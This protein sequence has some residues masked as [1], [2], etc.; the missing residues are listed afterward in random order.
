MV[1]PDPLSAVLVQGE[2][3]SMIG[4]SLSHYKILDKLGEGGMG[5]VYSAEDTR[6][7][8][9]V[10]LKV[11]SD[12]WASDPDHL[13]RFE[14]EARAVAA[15]DHPNI[16]TIFSVE[17][18]EGMRFFT[19][20]LVKGQTLDQ[21]L[22]SG[23][24]ELEAMLDIA[25]PMTDALTAAHTRGITHRDLKPSNVMLTEDGWVKLL[26]FGLAKLYEQ[27]SEPTS[28]EAET[29][30]ITRAGVVLGTIPYM[31]PEQVQGLAVDH[32]SDIFSLGVIFYEL[33]TGERPF[34]GETS[35]ALISSIMRDTPGEV[36]RIKADIPAR[37]S[38]V[39]ARCLEKDV[40]SRFQT[41]GELREELQRLRTTSSEAKAAAVAEQESG[42]SIAVLPFADMSPD[43]DQDY[44]CEGIAEELIN[45]LGRING[46]RVASRTSS[47]QFKGE[48]A[49]VRDLGKQLGVKT[50]LEG[51]VRKA[52][53]FLRITAQLVNVED[54]YRLWSDRFDREM[55]DV[56]AI[57]DEIAESIVEALEV[58]L[59]PK[60]RRALQ[61]VATRNAEA[62]DFYLKGRNFFYQRSAR[63]M[64]FAMQMFDKA[65]ETDPNY[66]LAYC[67]K[68]DCC[69]TLYLHNEATEANR[70]AADDASARALELD[71]DLAEA[72]ASRGLALLLSEDYERSEAE[73]E[74]ALRLN[75]RLFEAYY[76]YA[77]ACYT[78]GKYAKSAQLFEQASDVRPEDYQAPL[79]LRQALI[80]M[81]TPPEQVVQAS[82]KALQNVERHIELHPDDVRALYL[83]ATAL[84]NLGN[85][86]KALNWAGRALLLEPDDPNV[87]YNVACVYSLAGEVEKAIDHLERAGGPQGAN[88]A[89]IER[90]TDFDPLR[91]HPRFKALLE[92]LLEE[93]Q[94]GGGVIRS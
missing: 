83:G 64:Q 47:F 33:L 92:R 50:L 21:T 71:P 1:G 94:S 48:S 27:D 24:Y 29:E 39:L 46:L 6:L 85:R 32:R 60:E 23:G 65:I 25:I 59:S 30:A 3:L 84:M 45:G 9:Q 10:A 77:R 68:A 12:E 79:L 42:P 61:N 74:T 66:A 89:W 22:P 36:T 19:M 41:V 72:H 57:Q 56:F 88:R 44:F 78:Q 87:A 18:A 26:D 82:V 73:F 81:G 58:T 75:S 35:A 93:E 54:G 7:G 11:L 17:E 34:R 28:E 16:V 51:S 91:E 86:E 62:Y 20:G 49:D 69:S 4:R 52:G 2:L 63:A 38:G 43:K 8:R 5:A 15:L 40:A 70:K 55:K 31:S 80:G 67:G 53:N 76:F 13:R 37:M 90:D 14:R